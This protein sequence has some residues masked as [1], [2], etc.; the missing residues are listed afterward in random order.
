MNA[1]A[2]LKQRCPKCRRGKIFRGLMHM[3]RQCS[4]CGFTFDR[5]AGYWTGAM[6]VSSFLPMLLVGPVWAILVFTGQNIWLA[7]AITFILLMILIPV[8]FRYSRAIWL[9]TDYRLD[10]PQRKIE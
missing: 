10:A 2:I 3:N 8:T 4:E 6:F 7:F 1:P 9:H 5:E